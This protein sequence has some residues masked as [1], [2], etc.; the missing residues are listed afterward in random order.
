MIVLTYS[1]TCMAAWGVGICIF[2]IFGSAYL[3]TKSWR[4]KGWN[5]V[6]IIFFSILL[7]NI[8]LP[9]ETD[10]LQSAIIGTGRAEDQV[11]QEAKNEPKVNEKDGSNEE[12]II[13][14][15]IVPS[16]TDVQME[17][18]EKKKNHRQ[19][20]Q[21]RKQER[22]YLSVFR[23]QVK[24]AVLLFIICVFKSGWSIYFMCLTTI[25]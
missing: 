13:T 5:F 7:Y 12:N 20:C 22:K 17:D 19:A 4:K 18:S 11:K 15:P 16:E 23:F 1:R 24:M 21:M 3:K 9:T 25:C 14:E 6:R 8:L 2:G 10:K